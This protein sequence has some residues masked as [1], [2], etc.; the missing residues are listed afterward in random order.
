VSWVFG[1]LATTFIA[2]IGFVIVGVIGV[3]EDE[4]DDER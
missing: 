1:V 3:P 4:E 2:L